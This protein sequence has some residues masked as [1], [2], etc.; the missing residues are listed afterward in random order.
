MIS[1]VYK[2]NGMDIIDMKSIIHNIFCAFVL[3]GCAGGTI[4]PLNEL[5]AI[6]SEYSIAF[7]VRNTDSS[8]PVHIY[9]EGDGHAFD[10]RGRPTSDPTPRGTL[11]RDMAAADMTPNVAY[12]ARPCQFIMSPA[13]SVHDWTDGRFS[14]RIIDEMSNAVTFIARGR[15]VV[16]IG[17]SGGAMA[18][19]L[20][21]SRNPDLNVR[22]WI[23]IAGVLNHDDWTEYFG[24][25]PLSESLS[26][27]ELPH[28]PQRHYVAPDDAVVPNSL[29]VRWTD[30]RNLI[31]V[32]G[33]SHNDFSMLNVD[34]I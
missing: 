11:V 7:W 15:P 22:E 31:F 27:H 18:S 13:C 21:I 34:K 4:G 26:L 25:A 2:I 14:E 10:A 9:I 28:V 3:A 20:I 8:A 16:L 19:A 6:D 24:D 23:T 5:Q 32:P 1:S 30:G 33:A 12:L 29:S 17:Y